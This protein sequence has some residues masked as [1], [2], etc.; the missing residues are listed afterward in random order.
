MKRIAA[1]LLFLACALAWAAAPG[2]AQNP[3]ELR[4][5][6]GTVTDKSEAPVASAVVYLK[7]TRSLTIKTYISEERGEYHFSGLDPNADYEIHAETS[8]QTSAN[9]TVSSLDGRRE[10]VVTLKLDKEKKK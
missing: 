9:H 7:N 6:R 4:T 10:F 8:D 3:S 1:M 2:R 5:V